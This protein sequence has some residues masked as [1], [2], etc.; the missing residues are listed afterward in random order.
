MHKH[1]LFF[2]Y[3]ISDVKNQMVDEGY[4]THSAI[5]GTLGMGPTTPTDA[6]ITI[7]VNLIDGGLIEVINPS[8]IAAIA[9]KIEM[10]RLGSIYW[11]I[12]KGTEKNELRPVIK[13]LSESEIAELNGSF[14]RT[15]WWI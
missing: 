11:N 3:H 8:P 9:A 12:K 5:R 14:Q 15:V 1:F 2:F 13:E 10:N 7:W 6:L 4:N